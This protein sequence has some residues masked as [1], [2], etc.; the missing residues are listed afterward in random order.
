MTRKECLE[1][2]E[3][4]VGASRDEIVKTYR[5]LAQVWH[6]DRFPNNREL[7]QKAHVKLSK[8]NEAYN[9]LIEGRATPDKNTESSRN[10]RSNAAPN[11]NAPAPYRDEQVRY[12]GCDPRLKLLYDWPSSFSSEG[13]PAIIEV[14]SEGVTLVTFNGQLAD[15]SIC[16]PASSL[17]AVE[18]GTNQWIRRGIQILW[19][20]L[21]PLHL[22]VHLYFSDPEGIHTRPI[23]VNLK[24]RNA[25]FAH[26]LLKRLQPMADLEKW[27]APPLPPPPPPQPTPTSPS[28]SA[29]LPVETNGA[30]LIIITLFVLFAVGIGTVAY[31]T[32]DV[33]Q[34]T[35]P[36]SVATPTSPQ[37]I[38]HTFPSNAQTQD[39]YMQAN[40]LPAQ[41]QPTPFT[42]KEPSRPTP[43][44]PQKREPFWTIGSTKEEV[45]RIEGR[46]LGRDSVSFSLDDKVTH[47]SN[48]NG[49]LKARLLVDGEVV[50]K[51]SLQNGR[52]TIG[53]PL[54]NVLKKHGQPHSV[55]KGTAGGYWL[56]YSVYHTMDSPIGDIEI[57]ADGKIIRINGFRF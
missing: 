56:N 14:S 15:E 52:V 41:N 5:H 53:T 8:I 31:N 10:E 19:G 18:D 4:P 7:Q 30:F 39:S 47:W 48:R 13:V 20:H 43:P 46:Y 12:F 11:P 33:E 55:S 44:P 6:P 38:A 51:G 35:I 57:G 21:P 16:Y 50:E 36:S 23:D 25:Y 26:L 54:I 9:T 1:I 3:L 24:V 22:H 42:N 37:E 40:R 45:R 2:L 29:S 17:L 28:Q 49:Y 27:T 32:V 34:P